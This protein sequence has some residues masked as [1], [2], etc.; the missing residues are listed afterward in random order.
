MFFLSWSVEFCLLHLEQQNSTELDRLSHYAYISEWP[1]GWSFKYF[2]KSLYLKFIEYL[3]NISF[4][5]LFYVSLF[6]SFSD[7]KFWILSG[8]LSIYDL[9]I[10]DHDDA[11]LRE[12][13]IP[14]SPTR[15]LLKHCLEVDHSLLIYVLQLVVSQIYV[16][17]K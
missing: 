15:P 3:L 11:V 17:P 16:K 10:F 1:F 9:H 7:L 12:N 2:W 6:F 8:T 4:I 13:W 5:L 14:N